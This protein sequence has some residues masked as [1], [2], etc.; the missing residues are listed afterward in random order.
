MELEYLREFVH[1]ADSLNFTETA[2]H[3]HLAQPTLSKHISILEAD[4]NAQ[5]LRRGHTKTALT[6]EGIYFRGVAAAMVEQYEEAKRTVKMLKSRKPLRLNLDIQS[7]ETLV[8]MASLATGELE[9]RG[10]AS[11]VYNFDATGRG[12]ES[13]LHDETDIIVDILAEEEPLPAELA[14][15][16]LA[17]QPFVAIVTC[18]NPL[19]GRSS[20]DIG[21]LQELTFVKILSNVNNGFAPGWQAIREACLRRDF[22]PRTKILSVRAFTDGVFAVE[23]DSVLILPAARKELRYL[24]KNPNYSSV[25]V[26]GE[27]AVFRECAIY[28][29]KDEERVAPVV[30]VFLELLDSFFQK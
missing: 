5:L 3:F 9:A 13:L 17:E 7:N 14:S 28:R 19:A 20:V 26:T 6:E 22:E 23:R 4:F 25:P 15:R 30:N 8:T 27:G 1:L 16:L 12:V 10:T 18:D 21:E 24:A 2:R 11:I 29:A